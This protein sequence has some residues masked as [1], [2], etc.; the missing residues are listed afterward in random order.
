ME[1]ELSSLH[2][3]LSGRR[4]FLS[5][6][7][8]GIGRHLL[9]ALVR[10]G[11]HV[12]ALARSAEA[13][14]RV[15]VEDGIDPKLVSVI[16]AD[17]ANP[18]DVESA[19]AALANEHAPVDSLLHNAAIDP[20]LSLA[21][22]DHAFW[23]R[24]FQ[25]NLFAAVE[26]TRSA[27]PALTSCRTGRVVFFGSVVDRMGHANLSA[28]GASK[29]ALAALTRSLAHELAGTGTTV[30]C[31]V[32]GAI[33]VEK[34]Q[35]VVA[36]TSAIVEHQAVRRRLVPKDLFGILALLLSEAG[37]AITGQEIVVD[38]GLNHPLSRASFQTSG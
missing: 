13:A 10:S 5:G 28:Y 37:S 6:V 30:N 21:E 38:G 11:A 19:A 17:L 24:V 29:G 27:L 23:L 12:V 15:I 20:R 7:T 14:Q 9:G 33:L 1:Q 32:P 25:V 18:R 22:S 8:R 4:I 3:S 36:D 35:A 34:E 2:V 26:L 31:L 16:A